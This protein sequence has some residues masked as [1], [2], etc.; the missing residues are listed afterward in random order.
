MDAEEKQLIIDFKET[1]ADQKGQRVLSRLKMFCRGHYTQGCFDAANPHQTA[2]NLGANSVWRLI[3]SF[4]T[5]EITD[6]KNNDCQIEEP[7]T[8]ERT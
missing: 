2:Y 3:Q 1:F 7:E 4:L 8:D 5:A 6:D